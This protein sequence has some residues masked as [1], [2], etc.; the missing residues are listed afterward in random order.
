MNRQK[1]NLSITINSPKEK[2]WKVL[3]EDQTY[4]QWAA[5]FMEGSYAKTDWQEG[6]KAL[7][8]GPD[9]DGMSSRIVKHIPNEVITIEHRGVVKDGEENFENEAAQAWRGTQET[10]RVREADNNTTLEIEQDVTDDYAEYFKKAWRKALE[11]I[12]I[13]AEN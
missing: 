6:S 5:A 7:F 11:K 8:L 2:V 3:L 12:K 4:R 10:Y 9:G 1:L 13:L